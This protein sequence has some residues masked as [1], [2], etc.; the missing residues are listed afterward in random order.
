M[1]K[2]RIELHCQYRKFLLFIIKLN[3]VLI[4]GRRDDLHHHLT[5]YELGLSYI[6][7]L[8]LL[9]LTRSLDTPVTVLLLA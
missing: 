7:G 5:K 2:T 8:L 4:F 6:F 3:F 9:Q 1:G